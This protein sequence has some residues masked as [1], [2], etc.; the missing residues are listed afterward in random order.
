MTYSTMCKKRTIIHH[1]YQYTKPMF[2]EKVRSAGITYSNT[3][4]PYLQSNKMQ[5]VKIGD[6]ILQDKNGAFFAVRENEF[7]AEYEFI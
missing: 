3:G 2:D 6:W 7:Y 5:Y 1:C 4:Y